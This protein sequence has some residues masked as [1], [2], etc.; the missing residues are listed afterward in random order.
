MKKILLIATILLLGACSDI[1]EYYTPKTEIVAF[2]MHKVNAYSV[3]IKGGGSVGIKKL[4]FLIPVRIYDDATDKMWY[5][6]DATYDNWRGDKTG[7]CEVHI[8]TMDDL[9]GA[10]WSNGKFG[11]GTTTR[12]D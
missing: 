12:V 3:A 11:S 6:C 1:T 2:Y 7:H 4:P 5:M 8:R 9:K 10:G